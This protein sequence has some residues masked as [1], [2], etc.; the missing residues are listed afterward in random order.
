VGS[1]EKELKK[2]KETPKEKDQPSRATD[3]KELAQA[4]KSVGEGLAAAAKPKTRKGKVKGP[5]GKTY[6]ME[7]TEA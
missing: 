4:L 5:S 7:M 3:H 2:P 1:L 6:E